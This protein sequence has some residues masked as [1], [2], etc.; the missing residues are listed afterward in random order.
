LDK[1]EDLGP[2]PPDP[3]VINLTSQLGLALA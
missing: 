3:N 1:V 2:I